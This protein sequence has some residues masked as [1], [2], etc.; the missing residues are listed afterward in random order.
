[1][2]GAAR[3]ILYDVPTLPGSEARLAVADLM[4]TDAHCTEDRLLLWDRERREAHTYAN[5]AGPLGAIGSVRLYMLGMEWSQVTT[6]LARAA[7]VGPDLGRGGQRLLKQIRVRLDGYEKLAAVAARSQAPAHA[8]MRVLGIDPLTWAVS[9]P[10]PY[11]S[12]REYVGYCPPGEFGNDSPATVLA[13]QVSLT[14]WPNPRHTRKTDTDPDR[15]AT[16]V[17]DRV[18]GLVQLAERGRSEA[19]AW[20]HRGQHLLGPF[21]R[22]ARFVRP[23]LDGQ[24]P[25]EVQARALAALVLLGD[26]SAAEW[27][28]ARLRDT[29]TPPDVCCA[30]LYALHILQRDAFEIPL[31]VRRTRHPLVMRAVRSV[32]DARRRSR[33]LLQR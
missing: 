5:A 7:S 13:R 22:D 18:L 25:Q 1:M 15:A 2:P 24:F 9:M 30:S 17:V 28:H 14:R 33:W 31:D 3:T 12:A 8:A 29:A 21:L 6:G 16:V 4:A 26:P 23:L 10:R 19:L 11:L 32:V 20:L 27:A